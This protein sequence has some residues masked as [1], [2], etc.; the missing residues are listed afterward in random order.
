MKDSEIKNMLEEL[1]GLTFNL[2]KVVCSSS[3]SV[4]VKL[5][6]NRRDEK[7]RYAID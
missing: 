6:N 1:N 3:P 7:L 5:R 2:L 4:G